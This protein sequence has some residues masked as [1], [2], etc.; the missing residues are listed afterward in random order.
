MLNDYWKQFQS[1]SDIRGI[2]APNAERNV[3]INL[4]KDVLKRISLGFITY[5]LRQTK[6]VPTQLNI[7][8]G[9]DSRPSSI[10]IKNDFISNLVSRGVKVINTGMSSTP[11]M[12][13]ALEEL[14]CDAAV[15]ITASHLPMYKNGLKF[16]TPKG[17]LSSSDITQILEC[18]QAGFFPPLAEMTECTNI[19]FINFYAIHL[20]HVIRSSVN[21]KENYNY[22]LTGLKFIVDARNGAGGFFSKKV[23]EPLGGSTV[24]NVLLKTHTLSPEHALNPECSEDIEVLRRTVLES[25][26]D[27]G[28]IFDP[29]VDRAAI[30][31]SEGNEYNRNKLIALAA[32]IALE[33]NPGGTIVTDSVTSDGIKDFIE[34]TLGGKHRRF[35]RGYRNVINEAIRLNSEGVNAPLAIETSGHAAFQENKFIDDGAY[36]IAKLIALYVKAKAEGKTFKDLVKDLHEPKETMEIRLRFDNEEHVKYGKNIIN[37]L[38]QYSYEKP[39]WTVANDNYD[40]VRISVEDQKGWFLLRLSIHDPVMPLTIESEVEGGCQK[41][42]QELRPFF[43]SEKNIICDF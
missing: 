43:E 17:G 20:C 19:K 36:L 23:L 40:G 41:I 35:K 12:F 22:P 2:A 4:N 27:L 11:S 18:A 1:G 8:V 7:A 39:H 10:R 3:Q 13:M 24:G 37:R 9:Y 25:K 42:L 15:E 38:T 30:I 14:K 34:K 5:L 29:D 26:S 6:K 31:D 28:I 16:F 21:Q 32:R 33:D